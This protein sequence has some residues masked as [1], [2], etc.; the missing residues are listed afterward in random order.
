M[1]INKETFGKMFD[2]RSM[3]PSKEVLE[4]FE[5]SA[6]VNQNLFKSWI[7]TLGKLSQKAEEL[8]K[9]GADPEAYK[10]LYNLWGKMYGKAFDNFF[11]NTPTFSPF[12]DIMEPVK[13]A[14]KIYTDTFS[15]MSNIWVKSYH[16][17]TDAV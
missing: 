17:S 6:N 4:H 3:R 10:E 2:A 5:R 13:N 16:N 11:E 12:K 15:N 7:A 9:Q 8:S 14:A 1:N